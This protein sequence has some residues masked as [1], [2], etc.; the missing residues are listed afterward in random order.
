MAR[1][2][3]VLFVAGVLS[4]VSG[5]ATHVVHPDGS[6]DFATIQAAVDGAS[7]GD[8][9]QLGDGIFTGLGNR[10]VEIV[11]MELTVESQGGNPAGCTIDCQGSQSEQHRA[12]AVIGGEGCGDVTI[13]C[14][15]VIN[16][17]SFGG[18]GA[19]IC[20]DATM[21]LED[22]EFDGC[23]A[24]TGGVV[25]V[26]YSSA[27]IQGCRFTASNDFGAGTGGG[28]KVDRS[29]VQVID[30]D[31]VGNQAAYGGGAYLYHSEGSVVRCRFSSNTVPTTSGT[32]HFGGGALYCHS[33]S[34]SIRDCTFSHNDS[35]GK[36]GAL[37]CFLGSSPVVSGCTF[38]S[39]TAG[40]WGSAVYCSHS[41]SPDFAKCI[42]AYNEIAEAVYCYDVDSAPGLSCSDVFGNE[43]GDW[44][45]CIAEQ[46][47]MDDNFSSDPCFCGEAY[48]ENPFALHGYSPCAPWSSPCGELVGAHGVSCS[49]HPVEALSWGRLKSVYR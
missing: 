9:I 29:T 4:A 45:G 24:N 6:G 30:C 17:Q 20:H 46:A 42:F 12:F 33:S 41:S 32:Y 36:G 2:A 22:C 38:V 34:P 7:S 28:L 3:M 35:A 15:R 44:T 23:D 19:V 5:A 31:F 27:T 11:G 49:V 10:D 1:L 37:F 39:N 14:V 21:S 40:Y 8:V 47:G 16:G 26:E 43:A 13:R 48:P 25:C 18:G